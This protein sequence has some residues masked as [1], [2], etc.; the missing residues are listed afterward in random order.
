MRQLALEPFR[1]GWVVGIID[2]EG[3]MGLRARSGNDARPVVQVVMTDEDTILRLHSWTGLGNVTG[4]IAPTA[5][6]TKP[7]W[8]WNVTARDDAALLIRTIQPWLSA[9]RQKKAADILAAYEAA[10]PTRGTATTCKYGHDITPESGNLR[11]TSNGKYQ[12]RRCL[13]C[14]ARRQREHRAR[15]A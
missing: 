2:G 14:A 9:R 5:S 12:A 10:G 6:Q 7:H 11:I 4:P 13:K 8:R 15:T 1:L 3:Y